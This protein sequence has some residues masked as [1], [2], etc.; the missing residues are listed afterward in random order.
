MENP[1]EVSRERIADIVKEMAALMNFQ[2][3]KLKYTATQIGRDK[4]S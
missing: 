2:V 4:F 1:F 3:E